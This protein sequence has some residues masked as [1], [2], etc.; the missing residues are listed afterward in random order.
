MGPMD[1]MGT[2]HKDCCYRLQNA[3]SE[4][5]RLM[6]D[7]LTEKQRPKFRGPVSGH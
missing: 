2:E 1:S 3:T 4:M 6:I 7:V 5:V